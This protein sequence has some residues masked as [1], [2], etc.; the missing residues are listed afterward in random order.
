MWTAG[1]AW[2]SFQYPILYD[3]TH[4]AITGCVVG[5]RGA[6]DAG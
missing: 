1:G 3:D 6:V 4:A 5:L 2:N